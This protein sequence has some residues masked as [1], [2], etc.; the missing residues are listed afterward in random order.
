MTTPIEDAVTRIA[1][2][3]MTESAAEINALEGNGRTQFMLVMSLLT[4]TNAML[5]KHAD[6]LLAGA[7]DAMPECSAGMRWQRLT[8][9]STVVTTAAT[10]L[11]C[12][13]VDLDA[14]VRLMREGHEALSNRVEDMIEE[15][16][17]QVGRPHVFKVQADNEEEEGRTTQ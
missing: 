5:L 15:I 8:A 14:M 10:R 16:H 13:Q 12:P 6:G 4:T 9:I 17:G 2:L 3:L 7:G 1:K 11:L